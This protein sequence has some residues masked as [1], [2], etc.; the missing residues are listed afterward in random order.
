MNCAVNKT[1]KI[2]MFELEKAV[3][4]S[5]NYHRKV[6]EK[7]LKMMSMVPIKLSANII[8]PKQPTSGD[9]NEDVY[10]PVLED[11]LS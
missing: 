7:Y 1:N 8:R 3:K 10:V 6:K 5:G 9:A 11:L 4:L 2:K